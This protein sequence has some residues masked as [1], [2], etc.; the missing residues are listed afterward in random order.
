V[1]CLGAG[2]WA[3]TATCL[4]GIENWLNTHPAL[5]SLMKNAGRVVGGA[6]WLTKLTPTGIDSDR[7]SD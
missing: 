7:T 1:L 5:L 6:V 2:V 4:E 3:D